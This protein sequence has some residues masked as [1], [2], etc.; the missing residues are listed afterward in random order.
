MNNEQQPK[1]KGRP[2]FKPTDKDRL[3]VRMMSGLGK[4]VDD[5]A[6]AVQISRRTVFSKFKNEL[7]SGAAQVETQLMGNMLRLANGD[8]GTAFRANE[9]LLN[10]RFG[11]SRYAPPPVHKEPVL[12]KKEQLNQDAMGSNEDEDWGYLLRP[13]PN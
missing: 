6:I 3:I 13:R 9:F 4:S 12:G 8:D 5:I 11:W 2:R 10:C 7:K 1:S